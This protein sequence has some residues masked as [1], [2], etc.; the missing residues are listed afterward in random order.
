M[1]SQPEIHLLQ[2]WPKPQTSRAI[3]LPCSVALRLL[4]PLTMLLNVGTAHCSKSSE[5]LSTTREKL[6]TLTAFPAQKETHQPSWEKS[7]SEQPK[8]PQSTTLLISSFSSIKA[9]Q[10]NICLWSFQSAKMVIF[11][12]FVHIHSWIWGRG[13]ADPLPQPY[14]DIFPGHIHI[15][16]HSLV[17]S[18]KARISVSLLHCCFPSS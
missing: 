7:V 11:V 18:T 9:S 2:M 8:T 10:V 17:R 15:C 1:V 4:F 12:H 13:L 3:G 16:T 14:S 6:V 5:P